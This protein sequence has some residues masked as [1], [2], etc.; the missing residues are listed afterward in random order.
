MPSSRKASKAFLPSASSFPH[1]CPRFDIELEKALPVLKHMN[2]L[3][4]VIRG[5]QHDDHAM[6]FPPTHRYVYPKNVTVV[7]EAL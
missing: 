6:T 1:Y 5:K 3:W 2:V 7:K 4:I